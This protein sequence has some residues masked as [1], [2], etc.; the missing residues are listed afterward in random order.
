MAL[1]G[2]WAT[3]ETL[4]F[5]GLSLLLGIVGLFDLRVLGFAKGLAPGTLK[6]LLPWGVFGFALCAGSGTLFVLGM[7]ANIIGG[8][9]YD[10]IA[11]NPYLQWKLILIALAGINLAAY[12]ATGMSR[13]VDALDADGNAPLLAK[14]FAGASI[15]LWIGVIVLGRLIPQGL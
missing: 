2:A 12:Y 14:I 3:C 13:A 1:P 5:M 9:A 10:V 6:R 4:H 7:G 8:F 15:G 11:T